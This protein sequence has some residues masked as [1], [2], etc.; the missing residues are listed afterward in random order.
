MPAEA[1]GTGAKA[2]K[3]FAR[4]YIE[5][6]NYAARTGDVAHLRSLGDTTCVSCK[7]IVGNISDIYSRGGRIDSRGW[8]LEVVSVVPGQSRRHPILDLGIRQF[9]ERVVPRKG[10]AVKHFPGG[11]KPMTMYL[12]HGRG[13]WHVVR[14][15]VVA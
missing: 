13:Q 9:P 4:H 14:L 1:K 12:E 5:S 2:A 15:D 3:A 8:K 6:I 10:A 11:K 7:A